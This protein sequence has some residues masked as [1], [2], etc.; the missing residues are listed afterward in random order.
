M[1]AEEI[2]TVVAFY[3]EVLLLQLNQKHLIRDK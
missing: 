3:N 2:I 1:R